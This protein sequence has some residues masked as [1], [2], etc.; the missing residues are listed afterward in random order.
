MVETEK[1]PSIVAKSGTALRVLTI[2]RVQGLRT[3]AAKCDAFGGPE[4]TALWSRL[5]ALE[6]VATA[7]LDLAAK[8]AEL[9]DALPLLPARTALELH[10]RPLEP[11]RRPASAGT[12]L[13]TRASWNQPAHPR[14][15]EPN[16]DPRQL[17]PDS[18]PASAG[19]RLQT[20]VRKC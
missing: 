12:R 4:A 2:P 11:T 13:Q 10:V 8:A 16:L 7:K 1:E 6:G 15:L 20:R 9:Q 5:V 18:R 17:G 3:A 19:A 14:P